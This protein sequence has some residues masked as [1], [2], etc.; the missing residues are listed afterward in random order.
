MQVVRLCLAL[1]ISVI[2]TGGLGIKQCITPESHT[3]QRLMA[4]KG[5]KITIF[6]H[7]T[8]ILQYCRDKTIAWSGDMYRDVSG[9]SSLVIK[10]FGF[11]NSSAQNFAIRISSFKAIPK[12]LQILKVF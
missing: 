4:S 8:V 2:C 6:Y 5:A 10:C 1:K 3:V 7:I 12:C 11:T 9:I